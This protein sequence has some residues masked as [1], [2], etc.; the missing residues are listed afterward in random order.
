[1]GSILSALKLGKPILVMPRFGY[2][3]ETRNEHQVATVER[4]AP[5]GLIEVAKDEHALAERLADLEALT[6]TGKIAPWASES[7]RDTIG[8]FIL[9]EKARTTSDYQLANQ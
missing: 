3:G 7:L 6:S 2:L 8:R 5:M 4:L 9:Q 1:M